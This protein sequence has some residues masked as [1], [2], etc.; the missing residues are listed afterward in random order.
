MCN[1]VN[2]FMQVR[3]KSNIESDDLICLNKTSFY[4]LSN[5]YE[6]KDFYLDFLGCILCKET[7]KTFV[8][9]FYHIKLNHDNYSIYHG[10]FENPGTKMKE[11]H[12][13]LFNNAKKTV[14]K[15][16]KEKVFFMYSKEEKKMEE[17]LF[18]LQKF[19]ITYINK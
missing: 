13:V 6:D 7:F 4:S 18:N 14:L 11:G 17:I 19:D 10:Q 16:I 5:D 1:Y 12:I 8:G 15:G 2:T 3:T 9:L